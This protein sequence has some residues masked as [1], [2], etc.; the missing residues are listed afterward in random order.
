ML[1]VKSSHRGAIAWPGW[2][3]SGVLAVVTS[4]CVA[5]TVHVAKFTDRE[6]C[7]LDGMV[8]V[9]KNYTAES[10]STHAKGGALVNGEWVSSSSSGESSSAGTGLV[11]RVPETPAQKAELETESAYARGRAAFVT[12]ANECEEEEP[13]TTCEW[14]QWVGDQRMECVKSCAKAK[15]E[16][17]TK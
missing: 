16:P 1:S 6:T 15:V 13:R 4:G 8:L 9:G 14:S 7:A 10:A 3:T 17:L 11:C 5:H 2:V 12:A